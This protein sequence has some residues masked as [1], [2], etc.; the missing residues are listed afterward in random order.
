MKKYLY[1]V[2]MQMMSNLQYVFNTVFGFIGYFV[3]LFILFNVWQYLYSDPN[4]L[5]NGYNMAQMTWYVIITELLWMTLGGRRL[6]REISNEVKS[7]SI[8]YKIISDTYF[9]RCI[10][11]RRNI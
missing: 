4:E 6:C 1:I 5:I 2:K 11:Y 7:G 3:M 9:K 10:W 8:T